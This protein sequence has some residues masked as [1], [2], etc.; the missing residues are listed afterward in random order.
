MKFFFIVI[1]LFLASLA[2]A[3]DIQGS[4]TELRASGIS[5]TVIFSVEGVIEDPAGCNEWQMFAI[6]LDESGGS[7][8][9]ELVKYAFLNNLRIEVHGLGTCKAH[10]RSEDVKDVAVSRFAT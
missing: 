8:V 3:G 5:N 2:V 1:S 7:A 9:F 6:N 10:W 4:V